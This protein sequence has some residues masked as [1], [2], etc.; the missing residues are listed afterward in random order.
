MKAT[1][2][3][4]VYEADFQGEP[5]RRQL[6][7]RLLS[8]NYHAFAQCLCL[9]L[10]RIGYEDAHLAGRTGW[11]GR[12]REGG[13]DIEA[14]LPAGA[15]RRRVIVQAKQ[16]DALPVFQRS[17]DELRGTCL[18]AGAAEALLITTSTF[19]PVVHQ[20][21]A[22]TPMPVAPVRLLDGDALLDLL[23]RH[24]VG[25]W[26]EA[27]ASHDEPGRLGIDHAFFNDLSRDFAGNARRAAVPR[28]RGETAP[29]W[30]VTV[31]V[32]SPGLPLTKRCGGK[33]SV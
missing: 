7:R 8:L 5:I 12:S 18:R 31:Q 2:T 20:N 27:G 16:F 1:T 23:L 13:Y 17:V 3:A 14:S 15:G 9:L 29:R 6:R 32:G 30:L 10:G 25:V 22:E 4:P 19:S 11:K 28:P 21:A 24:R 26:E 33:G